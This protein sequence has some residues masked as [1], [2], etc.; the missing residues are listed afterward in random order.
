MKKILFATLCTVVLV[1]VCM[2]QPLPSKLATTTSP[3]IVQPD[4]TTITISAGV[5][6]SS[7]GGGG[8]TGIAS[9]SGTGIFN[10]FT[11]PVFRSSNTLEQVTTTND[12]SGNMVMD[13]GGITNMT[14]QVPLLRFSETNNDGN[15]GQI[16][17][18]PNHAGAGHNAPANSEL[19]ITSSGTGAY[20]GGVSSGNSTFQWGGQ[21]IAKITH[22]M[23]QNGTPA[24]GASVESGGFGYKLGWNSNAFNRSFAPFSYGRF[25]QTNNANVEWKYGITWVPDFWN[26]AA[27]ASW[28]PAGV[29]N[30]QTFYFGQAA[31][32]SNFCGVLLQGFI[33]GM[34]TTNSVEVNTN[35]ITLTGTSSFSGDIFK[36]NIA[37]GNDAFDINGNLVRVALTDSGGDLRVIDG[38]GTGS[39]A[40]S[41]FL[42]G[43]SFGGTFMAKGGL[44]IGATTTV[45]N[46]D[47]L[48]VDGTTVEGTNASSILVLSNFAL[49][50]GV[51]SN[52]TKATVE[53]S[54]TVVNYAVGASASASFSVTNSGV[55]LPVKGIQ[56]SLTGN[57][58]NFQETLITFLLGPNDSFGYTTNV[59]G[60]STSGVAGNM[61]WVKMP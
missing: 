15:Y 17:I 24:T 23:N 61:T 16:S 5:I 52:L 53:A 1:L 42:S 59:T 6:S 25:I 45:T 34:T 14:G 41:F 46:S 2:A 20:V 43:P 18:N 33:D 55:G 30:D 60:V 35:Q 54:V 4:G 39:A 22:Y 36:T 7:G 51:Y 3:G 9:N 48:E 13:Y 50:V 8:G 29:D 49:T 56:T 57:I 12:S 32:G 38:G 44:V 47:Q 19:G 58:T 28:T 37:T 11:N 10:T 40:H 27:F 26:L 31:N 21:N